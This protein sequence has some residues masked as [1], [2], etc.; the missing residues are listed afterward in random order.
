MRSSGR[1]RTTRSA[2]TTCAPTCSSSPATRCAAG[3]PTRRRTAPRPTTSARGSSAPGLKP[4]APDNSF[5]Q[6]YNLMTATLGEGNALDMRRRRRG[7]AAHARPGLLSA[8][9]QRQRRRVSGRWC[10]RDSASR[11]PQ[12]AVRR[13]QGDVE[14]KIVLVLDHEPGERDPTARSTASSRPSLDA[15]AQGAGGAGQRRGR[16]AVRQ[17]RAQPSRAPPTSSRRRATLAGEAAAHPRLHARGVGGSHPH[18]GRAD[19]AGACRVARR[20]HGQV[21][22]GA[23]ASGGDGAR[24][25]AVPLPGAQVSCAPRS[26]ATSCPIATSSR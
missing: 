6:N 10:S 19:L 16:R 9:L 8:A 1:R 4:A 21:A 17:R 7:A 22:R 5:F 3:S 18:S 12:L 26:I 23:R 11:A 20:R 24:L 2:R 15:V 13:L 14:G 25:H